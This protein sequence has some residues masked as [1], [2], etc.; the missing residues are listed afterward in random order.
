LL[1]YTSCSPTQSL[2]PLNITMKFLA[3]IP[4]RFLVPALL[5][6]IS[7]LTASA[8]EAATGE[9]SALGV[10]GSFDVIVDPLTNEILAITSVWLSI[11]NYKYKLKDVEFGYRND[12]GLEYIYI[13]GAKSG[14]NLVQ[15]GTRDFKLLWDP[16]AG[17]AYFSYSRPQMKTVVSG[18]ADTFTVLP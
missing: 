8:S 11:D 6:I 18:P 7:P 9:F 16:S 4:R 2:V 3:L 15:S 13:G 12:S 1:W 10:T 17:G 14:G 5:A